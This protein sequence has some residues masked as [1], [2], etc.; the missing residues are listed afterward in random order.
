MPACNAEVVILCWTDPTASDL[1][2]HKIVGFL[3]INA[4][5]VSVANVATNSG[6]WVSTDMPKCT[7][8][9]ADVETL[10]KAADVMHSGGDGLRALMLVAEH[11]FVYGFQPTVRHNRIAQLLSSEWLLGVQTHSES[12]VEFDVAEDHREWTAQ[13]SGLKVGSVD[14]RKETFFVQGGQQQGHRVIIRAGGKPFF[15]RTALGASMIF[16][17][18]SNELAD[19]DQKV[20]REVNNLI[21]FSRLMP[22]MMFLRGALRDRV[23]HNC[24]PRACFII[25]DPLLKKRYGFL[26]YK[27]LVEIMRRQKFSMCLAFIPWNYRRSK[28]EVAELFSSNFGNLC[29]HGCDHTKAEFA[30]TRFESLRQKSR[31]ALERMRAHQQLCGAPFDNVMVF[32]QGLFSIEAV[33]AL[34]A[35]DFLAA[36]NTDLCPS[37]APEA[38][39]LRN[40]LEVAVTKFSDFPLFSR[41][42]PTDL[43][44]F[45]LDLFIGKPVLVVEH[46]GYFRNGYA[47]L[48]TFVARLNALERQLEW[49]NLGTICSRACLTRTGTDGEIYVRFYTKQFRLTNEGAQPQRYILLHR[50]AHGAPLPSISVD[51]CRWNCEREGDDVKIPLLLNGGQSA[52]VMVWCDG[53]ARLPAVR[54]RTEIHNIKVGIR[55]LLCEFRDNYIDTN[56]VLSGIVA[57]IRSFRSQE[58]SLTSTAGS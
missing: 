52:H 34:G 37:T 5:I 31:L 49:T 50:Q 25:D 38:L 51:G 48:E 12:M 43:A 3:G 14:S 13:F 36:I 21:W 18:A 44:G 17:V 4:T 26:D 9:I 47:P 39:T 23:W 42:Y 40:L 46:H 53:L 35:S 58:Q 54:Y 30:I 28:K 33:A 10:A 19:L 16:L 1:R 15:V 57:S 45:A 11:I 22:L 24:E 27:A 56:R 41:R 7:C 2:A 6:S 55:R 32:P 8:L 20:R 29:V